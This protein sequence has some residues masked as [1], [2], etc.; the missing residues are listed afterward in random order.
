MHAVSTLR[1]TLRQEDAVQGHPWLLSETPF[2][3]KTKQQKNEGEVGVGINHLLGV[4]VCLDCQL[5][6]LGIT[7]ETS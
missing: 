7:M 4:L 5:G 6:G 3:H 2:K 1:M